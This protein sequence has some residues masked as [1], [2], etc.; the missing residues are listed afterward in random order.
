[1]ERIGKSRTKDMDIHKKFRLIGYYNKPNQKM[2]EELVFV[3]EATELAKLLG[4]SLNS[5]VSN[6]DTDSL[7]RSIIK[8]NTVFIFK[9]EDNELAAYYPYKGIARLSDVRYEKPDVTPVPLKYKHWFVPG[10]NIMIAKNSNLPD[11]SNDYFSLPDNLFEMPS[12]NNDDEYIGIIKKEYRNPKAIAELINYLA[13]TGRIDNDIA[14]KRSFA[15]R[16]TGR[17][18][19]IDGSLVKRIHW[20]KEDTQKLFYI[21]NRLFVSGTKRHGKYEKMKTFFVAENDSK[22]ES[23]GSSFAARAGADFEEKVK[24]WF[25]IKNK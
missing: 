2:Y 1:M 24:S 9:N 11:A 16:L 21:C 18:R 6:K 19:P 10:E 3:E 8:S 22:F 20:K 5:I 25:S 13:G 7:F 17:C 14:T 12:A 23:K 4:S 15:F